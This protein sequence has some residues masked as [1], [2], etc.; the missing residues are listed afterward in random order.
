MQTFTISDEQ[1]KQYTE[2]ATEHQKTCKARPDFSCALYSFI[3]VPSGLGDS[4]TVKCP[5]GDSIYLDA[6]VEF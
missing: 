3:F 5:C 4:V 2:W 6:G 1:E